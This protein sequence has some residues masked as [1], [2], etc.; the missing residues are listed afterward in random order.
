[1]RR[2][3]VALGC[4][5]TLLVAG[6]ASDIIT[7]DWWNGMT[8]YYGQQEGNKA[9]VLNVTQHSD[10]GFSYAHYYSFGQPTKV[11]ACLEAL[12]GCVNDAE[13]D[14]NLKPGGC[15]II[16]VNDT[17]NAQRSDFKYDDQKGMAFLAAFAAGMSNAA[18]Q[19]G[20]QVDAMRLKLDSMQAAS[21]YNS[22]GAFDP[23]LLPPNCH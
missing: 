20:R 9:L 17:W 3:W 19:N 16:A 14:S 6:C 11:A 13:D 1:M 8:A 10:G 18:A 22:R 2:V 5:A 4:V 12:K 7:E 15:R 21:I 23:K